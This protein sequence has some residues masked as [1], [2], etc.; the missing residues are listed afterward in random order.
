MNLPLQGDPF[1]PERLVENLTRVDARKIARA[2]VGSPARPEARTVQLGSITATL[3]IL[4]CGPMFR[5]PTCDRYCRHIYIVDTYGCFA[6]LGLDYSIRHVDRKWKDLRLANKWRA[7]IGLEPFPA[8]LPST[9][10]CDPRLLR[11]RQRIRAAETRLVTRF[12]SANHAHTSFAK[13]QKRKQRAARTASSG[14]SAGGSAA[15]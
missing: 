8:P 13:A 4:N 15:T 2:P 10:T 12:Q 6:C 7:M 9:S 1:P 3:E 5:C 11:I 14:G